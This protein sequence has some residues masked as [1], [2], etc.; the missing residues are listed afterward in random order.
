MRKLSYLVAA[1]ALSLGA[2]SAF[3]QE[4]VN[5]FDDWSVYTAENPKECWIVS[6]PRSV[7]NT[8]SGKKV[9]VNRGDILMQVTWVPTENIVG[10]VSYTAGYQLRNPNEETVKVQIG[11]KVFEFIAEGETAWP[12]TQDL[13]TEIRVAMTKGANAVVMGTSERSGTNTKDLFSLKG[14]TA[15]LNDAKE[16]CGVS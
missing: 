3:A 7:E 4:R 12:A 14:F 8:R 10:E 1:G 2:G 5:A 16:R 9:T 15:A 11:S 6:A 13:Y